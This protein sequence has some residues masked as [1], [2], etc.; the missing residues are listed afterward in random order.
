MCQAQQASFDRRLESDWTR[1]VFLWLSTAIKLKRCAPHRP[2]HF[3]LGLSVNAIA[4]LGR[5][6]IEQHGAKSDNLEV[7]E[8][9]L[10]HLTSVS[11]R[12]QLTNSGK[13]V[14]GR[15]S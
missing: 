3:E 9:R 14:C 1:E 10:F 6:A 7:F 15:V 13:P 8:H 12:L 5:K 11:G 4:T 2:S